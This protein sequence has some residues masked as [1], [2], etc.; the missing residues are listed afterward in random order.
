MKFLIVPGHGG[1]DKNGNY[2]VL[3]PGSKQAYVNGRWIYEGEHNRYIADEILTQAK[4]AGL[5]V[6]NVVPEVEDIPLKERVRRVNEIVSETNEKVFLFELHLNA[7]NGKVEGSEVFTTRLDNFSDVIATMWWN[8]MLKRFPERKTRPDYSDGDPDKEVDYFL[9]KN[10]RCFGCLIE[11]FFF[12][13]PIE[14]DRFCNSWGY[15]QWAAT[16]IDTMKQL[17]E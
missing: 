4:V 3:K 13:N 14:V 5:D 8:N 6:I 2:H 9:I 1:V 17:N 7:F 16:V 15:H 12:D 10:M 11:F